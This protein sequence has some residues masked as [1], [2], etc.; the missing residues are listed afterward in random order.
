M[1]PRSRRRGVSRQEPVVAVPPN[2]DPRVWRALPEV[3]RAWWALG[4]AAGVVGMLGFQ[5][6]PPGRRLD[7]IEA[8]NTR[9]DSAFATE[10][11]AQREA[12]DTI[13]RQL[14]QLLAGQCA[15][16]RDRMARVLYG[17]GGR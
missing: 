13:R 5:A 6:Y 16:E 3:Q 7:A 11:L 2:G 14:G 8:T 12:L 4:L 9:Q 15:K 1:S 17:C 10:V